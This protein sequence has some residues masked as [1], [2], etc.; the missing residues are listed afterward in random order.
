MKEKYLFLFHIQKEDFGSNETI[1]ISS[2]SEIY[3][4]P[5]LNIPLAL[6]V[7]R[8]LG[9]NAKII[10]LKHVFINNESFCSW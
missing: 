10:I 9:F 1:V 2:T 7:L 8:S 5:L 3:E 6:N 4:V